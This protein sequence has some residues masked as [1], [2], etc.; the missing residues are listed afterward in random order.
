[1]NLVAIV[2]I[3]F[4]MSADAFAAALGKGAMLEHPRFSEAVRTGLVFGI[5]EAVTP[6]IG[7]AAGLA[8]STY[9]TAIDHWIGFALLAAIGGKMIWR[10]CGVLSSRNGQIAIP[11]AC[12]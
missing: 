9:I 12:C 2:I 4:S 6:L 8:A 5:V 10:A 7:W 3:A 1:M 11:F